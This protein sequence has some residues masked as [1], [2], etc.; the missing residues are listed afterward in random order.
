MALLS[1]PMCQTTGKMVIGAALYCRG[2]QREVNRIT[3]SP[4]LYCTSAICEDSAATS[5]ST[6]NRAAKNWNAQDFSASKIYRTLIGPDWSTKW[7]YGMLSKRSIADV[8]G[9][10]ALSLTL[11]CKPILFLFELHVHKHRTRSLSCQAAEIKIAR[12][13]LLQTSR[14]QG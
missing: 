9:A 1:G 8:K 11:P 4:A 3:A 13:E 10:L 5:L 12:V 6:V 2:A 7:L 14:M